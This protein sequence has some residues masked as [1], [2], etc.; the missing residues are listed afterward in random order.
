[1]AGALRKAGLNIEI[2]DDHF[3]Q[4]AEDPEWLTACGKKNWIVI[5]RDAFDIV[6]PRGRRS[7]ARKCER[8]FWQRRAIYEQKCWQRFFSTRSRKFV[9]L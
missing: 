8:S 1:M 9:E 7:D 4:S 2:H 5:T 6:H 3:A